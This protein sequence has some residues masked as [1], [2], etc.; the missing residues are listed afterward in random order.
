MESK[1]VGTDEAYVWKSEGAD[2]YEIKKGKKDTV[3]TTIT[4]KIKED[5]E[6]EKYSDFLD[7]Y[8]IQSIV[9][10]YSDY[11]RYPIK[12]MMEHSKLK[13]GTENEYETEIVE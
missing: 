7:S 4:L 3:G 13:E 11:I 1:A 8:Q 9:K 12:M 10:K 2:G 5:T 6:E